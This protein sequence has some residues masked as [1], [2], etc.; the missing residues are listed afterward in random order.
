MPTL[1]SFFK[2]GVA[3]FNCSGVAFV[4]GFEVFV[5][6]GLHEFGLGGGSRLAARIRFHELRLSAAP[7]L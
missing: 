3:A 1:S 7:I 5:H 6:S 2:A 4:D